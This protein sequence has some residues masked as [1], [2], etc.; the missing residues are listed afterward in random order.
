MQ[1]K[2]HI[3]VIL[4]STVFAQPVYAQHKDMPHK[5]HGHHGG[6]KKMN[7]AK[8]DLATEKM[9]AA[10]HF[11]VAISSQTTPVKINRIHAW[12]LDIKNHSGKPL[13]DADVVVDGGMPAHGHGLPTA[14]RVT[15]ELGDGKY[16]V[17]GVRFNMG[18][19][20]KLTFDITSAQMS[21][22]VTFNLMIN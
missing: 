6:H 5:G 15:K 16:L 13:S 19:H 12:V 18:G 22:K 8:L 3:A 14:P 9:S 21:D 17:E 4:F 2:S 11:K 10:G 1:I 20:W 7:P